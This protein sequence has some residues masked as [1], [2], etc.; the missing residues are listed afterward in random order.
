MAFRLAGCVLKAW[1]T[2]AALLVFGGQN[3]SFG[4]I[5]MVTRFCH[6]IAKSRGKNAKRR[7][8]DKFLDQVPFIILSMNSSWRFGSFAF[9][10]RILKFMCFDISYFAK[11]RRKLSNRP[12]LYL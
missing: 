3:L 2:K 7:N 4:G 8:P 6:A 10:K 5:S 9:L 11:W 12:K 1:E